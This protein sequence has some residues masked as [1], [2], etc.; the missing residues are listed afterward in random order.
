MVPRLVKLVPVPLFGDDPSSADESAAAS[1]A[2]EPQVGTPGPQ[3]TPAVSAD[4]GERNLNS[5]DDSE[6]ELLSEPEGGFPGS[7]GP[8]E[9]PPAEDLPLTSFEL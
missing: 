3:Q 1:Q 7:P 5:L 8:F 2:S 9:L 6:A 4:Q